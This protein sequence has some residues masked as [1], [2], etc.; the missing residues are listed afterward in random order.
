MSRH[1]P[2]RPKPAKPSPSAGGAETLEQAVKLENAIRDAAQEL[3]VDRDGGSIDAS[4]ARYQN[5][6]ELHDAEVLK[7]KDK[8]EVPYRWKV[9]PTVVIRLEREIERLQA[10][11]EA[12][13]AECFATAREIIEDWMRSKQAASSGPSQPQQTSTQPA[14]RAIPQ[15]APQREPADRRTAEAVTEAA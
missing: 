15:A 10:K 2:V 14:S 6:L 8:V 1:H 4:I 12:L 13:R 5:L 11:R 9:A 3:Y 7:L